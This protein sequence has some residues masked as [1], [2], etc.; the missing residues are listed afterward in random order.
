MNDANDVRVTRRRTYAAPLWSADYLML[1]HIRAFVARRLDDVLRDS[2]DVLDAGCGEQP[3]RRHIEASG[4]RYV[5]LDVGQNRR[6]N[7]DVVASLGS[8]PRD[9]DS[10]DLIVC[11]EVLEHVPDTAGAFAEMARLVRPGGVLLLTAPFTYP[12]HEEPHDYVRLTTHAIASLAARHGLSVRELHALGNEVEV[13]ALT[14]C[15]LMS[16]AL[17]PLP[18]VL[19]AAAAPVR[20]PINVLVNVAARILGALPLPRKSYLTTAAVLTK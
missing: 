17:A 19:R 9:G 5:G 16:S 15:N 14:F 7:V 3:L 6:G 2:I 1:R 8:V 12:L 13:L 18:F 20:L 4:A 10:F 11:T